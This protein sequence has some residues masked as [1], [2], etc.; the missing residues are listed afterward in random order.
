MQLLLDFV[1]VRARHAQLLQRLLLGADFRVEVL[2][3][4]EAAVLR[5]LVQAAR[6]PGRVGLR[7]RRRV[8]VGEA[9]RFAAYKETVENEFIIYQCNFKPLKFVKLR[10]LKT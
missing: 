4:F 10:T 7:E 9:E 8:R 5:L 1:A 3:R 2:L 6:A